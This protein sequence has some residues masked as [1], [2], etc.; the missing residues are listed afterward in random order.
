MAREN[1]EIVYKIYR[2]L[3]C[4][5]SPMINLHLRWRKFRGLEHPKRWTERL[6]FPSL[7]RPAG[8]LVWFHAVSLGEG[9]AA[10]PVIK[11]CVTRRPDVTVL[12]TSTTVSAF[13]VIKNRLPTNVIYQFAPR[14]TQAAV[15]AFLSYWKPNA[16]MLMESE[17]WPNLIIGAAKNGIALALLN[18]RIS[19]KSFRRWSLPVILP[20]AAFLLSKFSLIVPLSNTQA[21][22]FQLLRAPPFVINFSGDLKYAIEDTISEGDHNLEELQE[23]LKHR[24][25]WMASS[26]HRGE[27]KIM[28]RVHKMLKEVYPDLV[29]IIV[30]RHPHQGQVIASELQKKG[31]S[32]AVRSRCD[33]VSLETEIFVVDTLGELRELYKLT[34]VAVIGG[35]FLPGLAGHN[36]SEAATAG[37]AVLTGHYLGHFDHM[38]QEMQRLNPSSVLQVSG[39]MLGE[40]IIELFGNTKI[41]EARRT[42]AKQAYHALSSGVIENIWSLVQFHILDKSVP[43]R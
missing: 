12:M 11:C 32:V 1:G 33:K 38:V 6:G 40:A 21:I 17:L 35:S 4:G 29:T 39:D 2:A 20:L 26:L 23:Q 18:A 14:D 10:I 13:E 24:K 28:L 9:M 8:P 22:H 25:V 7:P 16:I 42:A 30:P 3:T 19:A 5:L 43:N 15:E 27:D 34:P 37:C 41:L 36:I 31:I